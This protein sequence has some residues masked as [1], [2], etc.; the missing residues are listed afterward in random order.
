MEQRIS[1]L[2][3]RCK[4][5]SYFSFDTVSALSPMSMEVYGLIYRAKCEDL[6][7][8]IF[9]RSHFTPVRPRTEDVLRM[10]YISLTNKMTN[11][12]GACAAEYIHTVE[13]LLYFIWW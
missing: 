3:V 2:K 5:S 12:K 11:K 13:D 7:I 1:N 6:Q 4:N 10:I 9:E 8:S